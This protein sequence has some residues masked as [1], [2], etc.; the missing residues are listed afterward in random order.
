MCIFTVT[1]YLAEF[2][3][4]E[5]I[6]NTDQITYIYFFFTGCSIY[7]EEIITKFGN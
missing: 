1:S 4:C 3:V 6:P 2:Q 7:L 5:I